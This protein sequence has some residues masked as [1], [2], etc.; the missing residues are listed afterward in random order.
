MFYQRK[1]HKKEQEKMKNLKKQMI[2]QKNQIMIWKKTKLN[3]DL[4]EK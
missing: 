4:Q 2:N 1:N 3:K